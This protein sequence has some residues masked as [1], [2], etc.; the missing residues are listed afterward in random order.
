[1]PTEKLKGRFSHFVNI[2]DMAASKQLKIFIPVLAIVF[3]V[4]SCVAKKVV[5]G[6]ETLITPLGDKLTVNDG[7][8]V[9]ALPQSV[10]QVTVEFERS[11]EVPGPYAKYAGELLGIK[12]VITAEKESWRILT[13]KI[14]TSEEIDPSEYYVIE[15]NTLFQTNALALKRAGLIL[16]LNPVF[17]ERDKNSFPVSGGGKPEISYTDLGSDSYFISRSD[18]AYRL[19]KLDTAFIRIPYLVEKKRLLTQDQLAERA[20]KTL[21]EL[22][23]GKQMILTGEANVY[24]Q[25]SAAIDEINR[26][27]KEYLA[28]FAGKSASEKRIERYTVIPSK[29]KTSGSYE[30]FRFSASA[31]PSPAGSQT[32]TPVTIDVVPAGKTKDI[33]Y[34]PG[35]AAKETEAVKKYDKLYYRPPEVAVVRMKFGNDVLYESRKLIYQ[36][37]ETI[38]LPSNFILGK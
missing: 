25:S 14:E 35:M 1:M 20:A 22:R 13:V 16:D 3:S 27:E 36:L 28:L 24:P 30:I 37:G 19:V 8:L 32:G 18:T 5:T 9:Y 11:V 29:D 31:G 2:Q 23:E 21:L 33:V 7:S 34:L 17:Y 12:D 6:P 4:V 10:I 15:S 38:Q 26:M